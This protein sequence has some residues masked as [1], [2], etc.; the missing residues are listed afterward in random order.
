MNKVPSKAVPKTP[1]ELWTGR[2]PS[3][4]YLKV[5]GCPSEAKLYNPQSHKLDMKT[6]SCF[7]IGYP[8]RS[9][10]YRFYAPSHS[11]RIVETK[12]AEFLENV[13]ISG[14]GLSSDF[15]LKESNE[16]PP[17]TQVPIMTVTSLGDSNQNIFPHNNS[18][19]NEAHRMNPL[20]KLTMKDKKLS[21]L[22][23]D[24]NGQ[25]DQQ[26]LMITSHI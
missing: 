21:S 9:K 3:L 8:E 26:I 14:S 19:A 13:N 15:D 5:W 4:R 20:K 18:E 17:I 22:K 16:E 7:F 10:G 12:H 2:K 25:G 23:D 6:I 24:H 11:T 1:F